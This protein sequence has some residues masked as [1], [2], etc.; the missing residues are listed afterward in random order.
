MNDTAFMVPENKV[1][2]YTNLY[3][4]MPTINRL[5]PGLANMFPP[6]TI[7]GLFIPERNGP[8]FNE[9]FCI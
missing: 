2:R 8:L 6:G 1:D 3:A 7:T 9:T 5:M 4:Y